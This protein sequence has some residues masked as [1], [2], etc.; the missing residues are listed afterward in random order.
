MV[1]DIAI[2][3][4]LLGLAILLIL[5]EIFML[6][7]ITIAGIGG[8]I[9]AVGGIVYAYGQV[10]ATVGNIAL[11]SSIVVFGIAFAW[12]L[13]SKA[14]D[15]VALNTNADGKIISNNELGIKP[16]DEGVTLSRLNP[17]GK[18]KINGITAEAKSTGDFI[19]EE[20]PV[21]VL[22]VSANSILVTEK[23]AI[24]KKE[25]I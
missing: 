24:E 23:E 8:C 14:L 4:F 11:A 19:S 16:G 12:L 21:V 20:R 7:G 9:F 3:V 13:K 10:G 1:L 2:I 22:K 5:L 15:K 17:I 6:P 18:I 25:S